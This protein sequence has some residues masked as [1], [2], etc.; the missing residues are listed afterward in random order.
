MKVT[1]TMLVIGIVIKEVCCEREAGMGPWI[2]LTC[3]SMVM[4]L[5]GP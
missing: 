4:V 5:L 3:L 1:L 2:G